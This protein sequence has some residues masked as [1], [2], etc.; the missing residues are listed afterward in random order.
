MA[1]YSQPPAANRRVRYFDGQFL[2]DQDFVDEQKYNLDRQRRLGKVLHITGVV[3]GLV[4]AAG[5]AN[6]ITVAPGTALDADG[7][8]LVLAETR[9]VDLPGVAFNNKQGVSVVIVFRE[10]PVDIATTGSLSQRRWLEDPR[11]AA[12]TSDGQYTEK[13]PDNLP[14][15]T[16]GQIRLDANGNVTVDRSFAQRAGLR[17]PGRLG[18]GTSGDAAAELDVVGS[19]RFGDAPS[20]GSAKVTANATSIGIQGKDGTERLTVRQTG[21]V[22]VGVPNPTARLDVAG[23]GETKGE[24]GLS[25]RSGNAAWNTGS[26]AASAQLSF[27]FHQTA[28]YRHVL[29]TRHNAGERSGN[30]FDFFVWKQGTDKVDD[31]GT[32]HNLTLDGGNV[33]LAGA[34]APRSALDTGL[35]VVT[36]AAN[37]YQKAQQ[38]LT[39]GGTVT[40]TGAR[41]KWSNRFIALGAERGPTLR[42]GYFDIYQPNNGIP[43]ANVHDANVRTADAEGVALGAWEVLYAVHQPGGAY[44][45]VTFQLRYY[46]REFTAP[47]NWI[48]VAL[49]NGDDGSVKLGTG[50]HLAARS[51]STKSS[52]IPTGTIVMWSGA[53]DS[54]PDGWA[55]CDGGNGT[56]DLVQRFVM[57]AHPDG[58]QPDGTGKKGEA[59]EHSHSVDPPPVTFTTST[60]DAHAHKPPSDWYDRQLVGDVNFAG[61]LGKSLATYNAIDRGGPSVK[62]VTTSAEG[63]HSH[64]VGVDYGPL[65]STSVGGLRPRWYALSYIM[66]L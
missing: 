24:V 62:N 23:T 25:V 54:I 51:S 47:S 32:Q 31:I 9:T 53:S 18:V 19:I 21:A 57:G 66:K 34:Y 38:V 52:P 17:L 2:V 45:A 48:L 4:V 11:I 12:V 36:G 43:A 49:V 63:A 20:G 58:G 42:S 33:G 6:K 50:V 1:D 10:E 26:T 15:V 61:V 16:L 44:D 30:A 37:D 22:G 7:R 8:Y 29:R 59:S 39:G 65:G 28:T 55:L 56:P 41:L 60:V 40:W 64:T 27:G 35:G 3:E 5:G 13:W 46:Q 14:A